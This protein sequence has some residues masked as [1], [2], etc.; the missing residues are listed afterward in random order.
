M[1]ETSG[2]IDG[3]NKDRPDFEIAAYS[4]QL[5]AM[6]VCQDVY[7]GTLKVRECTTSYLP[8]NP[9]EP[10]DEY[11]ARVSRSVL[12][13]ALKRAITLALGLVFGKDPSTKD[14]DK[15]TEEQLANVDLCG[16][17]VGLFAREALKAALRDG[18]SFIYVDMPPPLQQATVTNAPEPTLADERAANMR[19]YMV[20]YEKGQAINWH[21][22]KE[23][24]RIVLKQIT[25]R[26]CV[27][28][29]DGRFGERLVQ[30][31]R[32]LTP[33]TVEVFRIN[34]EGKAE[35]IGETIR[36]SLSY[37]P[38]FPVYAGE[39]LDLLVSDPPLLDLA[40]LN[41]QHYQMAS[42]LQGILHVANV[43]ILW[44]RNR[45]MKVPFTAVG[46]SVLIDLE[47]EH[48]ELG[49]AEHQ[50]HAIEA[51]Q[52]EIKQVEM[53]MSVA[54]FELLAD[55]TKGPE[56]ATGEIKDAAESDSELSIAVK[57]LAGALNE[58]LKAFGE[59]QSKTITG[60][61]ELNVEYER[62]VLSVQEITELRNLANDKH[63]S[64]RTLLELM[65]RAG[66]L[67][68]DFDIDQELER[69]FGADLT[70]ASDVEREAATDPTRQDDDEADADPA[71]PK[72]TTTK[73]AK[74]KPTKGKTAK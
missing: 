19:P 49:Y 24:G 51:A 28:E 57:S 22:E 17:P 72:P 16:K 65:K 73:P 34:S 61:I 60:A 33:G 31:F 43:P 41:V 7:G 8:K 10:E 42:D 62:L 58:A 26:E 48:S 29:Q 18:H 2:A 25:F 70:D 39:E 5:P 23:G 68:G 54:G 11:N 36:T 32:V 4:K 30:Q 9:A 53:R 66:K 71:K 55:K 59:Y 38:V 27:Y 14:V 45:N 50:G 67:P 1:P 69:I 40:L 3:K 56:T 44:A 15:T 35:Q 47:G 13:P 12:L 46:P 6:K 21:A 64:T 63:L 52:N 20:L 74:A 37:I